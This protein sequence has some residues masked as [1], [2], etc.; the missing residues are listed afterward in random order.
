MNPP[1]VTPDILITAA[2]TLGALLL[3]VL[4]RLPIE[5]VGLLVMVALVLTGVVTPAEGVSGFASEAIVTIAAMFVLSAALVRTGGV[6]VLG[7]FISKLAGNSDFRLLAVSLAVVVPA[8]AFVNNTPVVVVMVPVLLGLARERGVPASRLFMP[9]SFASQ[10][11]GTL[12]LVGTS[13][14]LLV[15]GL[16]LD[17]GLPRIRLFDV[18][19][20]ALAFT[21]LG[22][23]YLLTVGR[24]LV[25][26]R[27]GEND[28]YKRYELGEYLSGLE[29]KEGSKLAGR[30]LQESGLREDRGLDVLAIERGDERILLPDGLVEIREGDRLVVRGKIAGIADAESDEGLRITGAD[31]G[32]SSHE[33]DGEEEEA[34]YSELLVPPRS[35]VVGHSLEALRFRGSYGVPVVGIR[36]HGEPVHEP[37]RTV[38]LHAGDIL[39]VRATSHDLDR[40]RDTGDLALLGPLELPPRRKRKLPHAAAVILAVVLLAAFGVTTILVAALAGVVAV[41]LSGCLTPEEAYDDVDWQPLVLLGSILPLGIA[42]QNTGAAQLAAAHFL[43][44]TSSLGPTGVLIAFY[45]LT[46]LLTAIISNAAAAVVLT[47]LAVAMGQSLDV[48][49]M[50]FVIAVI[51]AASNSFITPVG[52]QTNTF[53]Y[54]PGGYQ[55]SDF[56]RVGGP[57]S[58]LFAAAAGFVIPVFFPF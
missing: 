47:P 16:A 51:L 56:L 28:L 18:T 25:P 5:V 52:Y 7:R 23:L 2:I 19:A 36:R 12:T 1:P 6:D 34:H 17:L 30:P 20:P 54:G 4:D 43:D 32:I 15:A 14:N 48:S 46:T 9:V 27:D 57:L 55:F 42:M 13:T 41:F 38:T 8:S 58:L 44:L 45:V 33:L 40:I 53:I 35:R 11:G 26:D 24:R 39:L 21:A 29:V 50:P 10:M 22:V 49:P 31:T 3:F 37:M